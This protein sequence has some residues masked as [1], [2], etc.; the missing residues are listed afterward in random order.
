MSLRKQINSA[1][2]RIIEA[3]YVPIT[4][5]SSI[6]SEYG[7]LIIGNGRKKAGMIRTLEEYNAFQTKMLGKNA[8]TITRKEYN[9]KLKE[10]YERNFQRLSLGGEKFVQRERRQNIMKEVER[11]TGEHYNPDLLSDQELSDL[12]RKASQRCRAE[13]GTNNFY[14][15]LEDERYD[16]LR[17]Q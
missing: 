6:Q 8:Q 14:T 17:Y 5:R 11:A 10:F 13:S 1:V 2:A 7:S 4:K 15:Y 3:G 9:I 16:Y 12:M